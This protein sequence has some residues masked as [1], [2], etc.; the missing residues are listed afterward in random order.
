[1]ATATMKAPEIVGLL[2]L[3]QLADLYESMVKVRSGAEN[4]MRSVLQETDD[5]P[6]ETDI[7]SD[8]LVAALYHACGIAQRRMETEASK[9][10][11]FMWGLGVPGI[12]RTL[13]CRVLGM[14]PMDGPACVKC[15]HEPLVDLRHDKETAE[16]YGLEDVAPRY[17]CPVCKHLQSD[18]PRF[19]S[20][21]KFSGHAP[22]HNKLVK[23]EKACFSS[24][25]RVA[26]HLAFDCMLKGWSITKTKPRRSYIEIYEKWRLIYAQ[27]HGVGPAA[28][29]YLV[30]KDVYDPKIHTGFKV[31][32]FKGTDK[33]QWLENEDGSTKWYRDEEM[34]TDVVI[35]SPNG[36][37]RKTKGRRPL[38]PDQRQHFAAKYKLMDVFLSHLWMTWRINEG[39]QFDEPRG[40]KRG[41]EYDYDI[42]DFTSPELAA[43]KR[44]QMAI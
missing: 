24:R 39:W 10:P 29:A 20:L 30:R 21:R 4:R 16:E 7:S 35:P 6:E 19:S 25:L 40:D 36:K 12:N 2:N 1:M 43:K 8:E 42:E 38:W 13:L 17:A 28:N 5:A 34:G 32:T 33:K 11:C 23:G 9:H 31:Y 27:R 41:H 18:F 14:I 3:R 26:C 15:G 37:P 44:K 22:G